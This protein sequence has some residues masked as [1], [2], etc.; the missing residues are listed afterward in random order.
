MLHY[1]P[2]CRCAT[3]LCMKETRYTHSA[4]RRLEVCFTAAG[5][6]PQDVR[7]TEGSQAYVLPFTWKLTSLTLN[8]QRLGQWLPNPEKAVGRL[9]YGSWVSGCSWRTGTTWIDLQQRTTADN[10]SLGI[11]KLLIKRSLNVYKPKK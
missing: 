5:M 4:K 8:K 2:P 11:S 1:S 3:S 10:N 9:C 6:T 7:Q